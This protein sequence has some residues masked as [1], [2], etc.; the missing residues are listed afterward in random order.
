M[1]KVVIIGSGPAGLTAAIYA[2]RADLSPL[3]ISGSA[4]GGQIAVTDDVENYPG[5]PEGVSG[6]E[7][8]ARMQAQAERFGMRMETNEIVEVDL[9]VH[10]FVLKGYSQE[11]MT[12]TLIIATGAS[13]KKLKVPGEKEFT[14]KGVSYC[15]TCDGFFYRDKE[16]AVVG[17]G[18]VA[19]EEAIFL[20]KFARKVSVIHRRDQLRAAQITQDRAKSNEKISFVWDSVVEEI[21]GDNQQG[22]TEVRLKNVKTEEERILSADGVFIFIGFSPNT[23]LFKGQLELDEWGYLKC[24]ERMRTSVPGVFGAGDV[25]DPIYHQI[26]TAIGSATIAAIEAEKFIADLEHRTYPERTL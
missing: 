1:E 6:A 21:L 23:Q 25:Q 8:P 13:P 24:D 18:D 16:V 26:S 12:Q 7:L 20:T 9:S 15:A 5:F 19:V 11:Y 3:V 14:G 17:G 10:P 22:V 2:G 4:I